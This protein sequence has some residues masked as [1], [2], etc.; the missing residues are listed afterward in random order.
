MSAY[1]IQ[2]TEPAEKDLC[3]IGIY[4]SKE[5]LEPMTAKK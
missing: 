3:E 1:D 4:I 5:L 2:I